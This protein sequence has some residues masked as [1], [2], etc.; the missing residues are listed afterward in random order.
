M[1]GIDETPGMRTAAQRAGDNA[2]ALVAERLQAAGWTV[3]ARRLHVG[4]L[5][6]DLVAEDPGPPRR[7]VAVEV[8][9]RARRDF[10]LAEETLDRGKQRRLRRAVVRL[11]VTG[12]L[13]DGRRLSA[14]PLAVDLVTV[15]PSTQADGP[16]RIR[17]HRDVLA[18]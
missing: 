9:W 11:A 13:P 4:R 1:I 14:L 2:E 10:G 7:L 16:P 12:Q 18:G 8:R 3:L 17:H 5:E 6:L 15:E